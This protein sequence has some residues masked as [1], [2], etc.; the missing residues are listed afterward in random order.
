MIRAAARLLAPLLLLAATGCL[1]LTVSHASKGEPIPVERLAALTPGT[2]TLPEVL[3]AL[4]AP[5]EIHAHPDGRL[6]VWRRRIHN[7]SELGLDAG[8]LTRFVDITQITSS[9]LGLIRFSLDRIHTD[10]ERLV[11]LLD[12]KGILRGIGYRDGTK[13]LP[14]F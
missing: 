14:W 8:N 4:G 5:H 6:L 7:T 12:R 1:N 9:L 3:E 11:V 2:S 13:D 10:E